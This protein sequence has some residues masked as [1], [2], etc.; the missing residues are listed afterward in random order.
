MNN[1]KE[2]KYAS[3]YRDWSQ[4]TLRITTMSVSYI[5]ATMS[6]LLIHI[7]LVMDCFCLHICISIFIVQK[8]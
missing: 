5:G 4:K 6:V 1:V 7:D 2:A 3:Y 8:K